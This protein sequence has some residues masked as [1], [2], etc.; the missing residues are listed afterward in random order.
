MTHWMPIPKP[1]EPE[2]TNAV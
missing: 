1:P 2:T